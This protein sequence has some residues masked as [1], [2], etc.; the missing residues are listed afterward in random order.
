M[1]WLLNGVCNVLFVGGCALLVV[2]CRF[3]AAALLVVYAVRC[4]PLFVGYV[5]CVLL[6]DAL[7]VVCCVLC[8][9]VC[10]LPSVVPC[11]SFV[12]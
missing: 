11:L 2:R 6:I 5:S 8:C 7:L 12:C 1:C 10:C 9:F 3:P 4:C